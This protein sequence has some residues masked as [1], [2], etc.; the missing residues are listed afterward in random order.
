MFWNYV[1][2]FGGFIVGMFI[3]SWGVIGV[4]CVLF[5]SYPLIKRLE[6]AD[7]IDGKS[8]RARNRFT[9]ILW[10]AIDVAVGFLLKAALSWNEWIVWGALAGIGVCFLFSCGKMTPRTEANKEDFMRSYQQFFSRKD[11]EAAAIMVAYYPQE[12]TLE[13]AR[14]EAANAK[15]VQ[16]MMNMFDAMK[17]ENKS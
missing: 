3:C 11:A 6:K 9:L 15:A 13:E 14:E 4:G 8:A 10:L 16:N 2:A 1:I 5:T 17:S 7:L 12:M